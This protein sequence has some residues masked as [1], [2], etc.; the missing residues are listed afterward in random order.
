MEKSIFPAI[1]DWTNILDSITD[2]V[3]IHDTDFNTLHANKAAKKVL[4]LPN[5]YNKLT[6]CYK[7]YHGTESPPK[8]CPSCNCIKSGKTVIF[9]IFEPHL[10]MFLEIRAMPRFNGNGKIIGLIH[11]ARDISESIM[12]E[13]EL[14]NTK[15]NLEKTVEE[16]TMKFKKANEELKAEIIERKMIEDNLRFTEKEM[17][18]HLNELK[19]ANT[20]L[21]VLMK[22]VDKDKKELENNIL[23]NIKHLIFPYI[24]KLKNNR[25]MSEELAYLSIIESNLNE[26]ILPFSFR[27]SSNYIGFSP[28]EIQIANLIKEGK[29]D[30]DISGLLNIS[31]ETVKTHRK[32]IRKKLGIYGK[33]TNLRTFLAFN[34]N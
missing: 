7:Y 29:Q 6:K 22:Q 20:A 27:L 25:A 30:K 18:T 4:K 12:L 28:K 21:K 33:R 24:E 26:I 19:E 5:I 14:L 17:I 9:E 11:I 1:S 15:N 10:G 13:A 23:S 8:G 16:R 3:T 31:L 34:T 2:I 32:N